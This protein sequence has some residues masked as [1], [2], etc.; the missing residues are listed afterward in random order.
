MQ[1]HGISKPVK[2]T[3][4]F[5]NN[6]FIFDPNTLQMTLCW[7]NFTKTV[8]AVLNVIIAEYF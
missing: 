6:R 7:Y 4:I 2:G 3:K 1:E 8:L 5:I